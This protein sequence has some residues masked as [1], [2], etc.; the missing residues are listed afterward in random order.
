MMTS[1]PSKPPQR[2]VLRVRHPRQLLRIAFEEVE[3]LLVPV[4][5]VEAGALAV[6]LVRQ[7]A[8]GDDRDATGPRDSFRSRGAAPARASQQRRADRNRKLQHAD[9]QRHDRGRP[10][11][12]CG[13]IIDSGEKQP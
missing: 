4:G 13:S 11:G 5:I 6:D 8:G 9:L 12:S 10:R 7:A 1:A 2:R 3:K